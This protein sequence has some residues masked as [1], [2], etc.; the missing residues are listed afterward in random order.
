MLSGYG[1]CILRSTREPY[2]GAD[3]VDVEAIDTE[4]DTADR[5]LWAAFQ[6][7]LTANPSPWVQCHFHE[8]LNNQT[9][10]LLFCV[11]RNHRASP[12]WDMIEWIATNGTGSYGLFYVHDDED[13]VDHSRSGRGIESDL[14]NV[15]RVHRIANGVVTEMDD[16]FFGPITP[17]LDPPHPYDVDD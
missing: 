1:W 13:I 14:D 7:W 17:N 16:P 12:V 15:F 2:R 6:D 9:G 5:G 10:I 8:Q 3:P 4:V 11:S